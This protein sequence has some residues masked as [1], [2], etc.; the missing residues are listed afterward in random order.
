MGRQAEGV[1]F[2][3]TAAS[4]AWLRARGLFPPKAPDTGADDD[5]WVPE[6]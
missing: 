4:V 1:G 2:E 3:A 6:W 5:D